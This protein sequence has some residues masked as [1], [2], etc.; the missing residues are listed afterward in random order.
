MTVTLSVLSHLT[1]TLLASSLRTLHA[2]CLGSSPSYRIPPLPLLLPSVSV[3]SSFPLSATPSPYSPSHVRAIAA[4][5]PLFA[6]IS[7]AL[8]AVPLPPLSLPS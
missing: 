4:F 3:P 7:L 1:I 2:W 8:L 5:I 6:D